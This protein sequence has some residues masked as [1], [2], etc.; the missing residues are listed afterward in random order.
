MADDPQYK[1]FLEV[2][3]ET[4]IGPKFYKKRS[5]LSEKDR[6]KVYSIEECGVDEWNGA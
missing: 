3:I 2:K 6:D 1:E 5:N 4:I